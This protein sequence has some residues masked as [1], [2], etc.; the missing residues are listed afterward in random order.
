[1][2]HLWS[3]RIAQFLLFMPLVM[4]PGGGLGIEVDFAVSEFTLLV[5]FSSPGELDLSLEVLVRHS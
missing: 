2:E 1:M 4:G 3:L 5:S